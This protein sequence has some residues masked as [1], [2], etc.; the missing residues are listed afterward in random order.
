MPARW[1]QKPSERTATKHNDYMTHT[2][3]Q[4][5][6][7]EQLEEVSTMSTLL[8]TIKH[9]QDQLLLVEDDAATREVV[10]RTL[11]RGD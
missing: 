1:P 4:W 7:T 9:A 3:L 11:D 6:V 8:D 2:F 10:R 5:F